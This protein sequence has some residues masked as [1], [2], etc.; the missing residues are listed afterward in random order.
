M[1]VR[2]IPAMTMGVLLV[3][4]MEGPFLVQQQFNAA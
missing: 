4:V 1:A 2:A 3:S